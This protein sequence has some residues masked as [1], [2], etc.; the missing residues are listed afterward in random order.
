MSGQRSA[1]GFAISAPQ[2]VPHLV[3]GQG[4]AAP[5]LLLPFTQ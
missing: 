1:A 2:M 4:E 3:L 5:V